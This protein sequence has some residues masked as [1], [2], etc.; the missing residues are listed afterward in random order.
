MAK[1]SPARRLLYT[2]GQRNTKSTTDC[3]NCPALDFPVARYRR[4][5]EV[6]WIQPNIMTLSVMV[7][8]A[9][10]HSKMAL[11]VNSL[12]GRCPDAPWKT[13]ASTWRAIA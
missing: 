8:H 5:G 12:H 6:C 10:V 9:T 2:G 13:L 11:E 4:L 7:Q 1:T 3:P